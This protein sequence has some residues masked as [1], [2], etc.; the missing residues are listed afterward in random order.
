MRPGW[1][2]LLVVAGYCAGLAVFFEAAARLALRSDALFSRMAGEDDASWRLRWVRRQQAGL[3]LYYRFDVHHPTRGWALRP[4][5][6]PTA[7]FG[8]KTVSSNSHGVRGAAER[9][10]SK[11]AG[12]TRIVTLGD[13]FTFGEDV[14]DDETWSQQLE[15]SL[16][17]TEVLNLGVH[18]YAHDQMLLYLQ[19]EG[20]RY[21]PDLVLLGFMG[22]DMERNLLRFRDFAKPRFVLQPG[23]GLQLSGTPVPTP[24]EVLAHEIYRSKFGDLLTMLWERYRSRSGRRGS[25]ERRLS[26]AILDEIA[27]VVRRA[28]A[29]PAFA[30]LPVYGELDKPDMAMTQRE[31]FFFSYCRERG[32]QSMYLRRFFIAAMKAG[33]SLKTY[34]HWGPQE[35]R[36]AAEAIRAYL[37][38]KG[39]VPAH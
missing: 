29:V 22:D 15:R 4:G 35:H 27:A 6:Q 19:E 24:E 16:P 11:P 5:L 38:E 13:S 18:G 20:I 21:H 28:G 33:A 39:L 34:G 36:I 3:R 25:D 10:Y 2:R 32:I 37:L 31:R 9:G 1:R 14:G 12:V 30:Y 17:G 23:G 8:D 26:V 7:A